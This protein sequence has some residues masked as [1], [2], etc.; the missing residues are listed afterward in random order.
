MN[1]LEE[2]VADLEHFGVKPELIQFGNDQIGSD[3][4]MP[5]FSLAQ[6]LRQSPQAI[7]QDIAGRL[8]HPDINRTEALGGYVNIWLNEESM[9][10]G[11]IAQGAE[12]PDYGS[13]EPNNRTV[14]VEYVSPNLAKPLS[15][16]H[17]R[18]ALQGRALTNL[19]RSQGYKV[20][21]DSHLGDWGTVFGMWVVGFQTF[22]SYEALGSG[23][24][25]ELGRVYVE[26]RKSLKAEA[27]AGRDELKQSVQDWLIK[28]EAG[29]EEAWKYHELF[30]N[31]SL[32]DTNRVLAKLNI[33]FDETLGEAFYYQQARQLIEQLL[34]DGVATKQDDNSVI[35]DLSSENL[36]TPLLLQKSNGALLYASTDIA[37]IKYREERWDPT[38]VLYV[39][40]AEQQFHFRQ[41]FAF[42]KLAKY[43]DADLVHYWY[44]LVEEIGE[45]G[46]RQKMSS[47]RGAVYLEDVL[48]LALEKAKAQAEPNMST[49]DITKVA[50]GAISYREFLQGHQS[51]VLFNWEEMFSLTGKSGPYV[52]YAAV[53]L[54]S[55]LAKSSLQPARTDGYDW[56]AEHSLLHKLL[57]YPA[58]ERQARTELEPSKLA[59]Y[60]YDLA[61]D[62]N[63]YYETTI[64]LDE[65]EQ[66]QANRLWLMQIVKQ[67]LAHALGILGIDIPEKM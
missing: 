4:A 63:R 43:S 38:A 33:V 22:S 44:G 60:I 40:G 31:I 16:G 54:N 24:N 30:K 57:G 46:Q 12:N 50:Y 9:V 59:F 8:N 58:L 1:Y 21:T 2:L 11:L 28:L 49:E 39:V 13:V 47:R 26:M 18:N 48:D 35:V 42:N 51:N 37:T 52:Q 7:A 23:G 14:I 34:S 55:I 15:I 3:I 53:R 25:K 27:E 10:R 61:K 56:R 19:Y 45:D 20:I 36:E 65:D 64:V 66:V 67:N 32:A 6:E 5:C 62:L 17:L 41:L 29:D